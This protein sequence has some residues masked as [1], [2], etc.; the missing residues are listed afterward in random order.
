MNPLF[1][2]FSDELSSFSPNNCHLF[3]KKLV[4]L[5]LG[6]REKKGTCLIDINHNQGYLLMH[7]IVSRRYLN[8]VKKRTLFTFPSVLCYNTCHTHPHSHTRFIHRRRP[9]RTGR[10]IKTFMN[11]PAVCLW[12]QIGAHFFA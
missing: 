2:R 4:L 7:L 3:G 11:T 5:N 6:G 9:S 1:F 8:W 10:L 12:T